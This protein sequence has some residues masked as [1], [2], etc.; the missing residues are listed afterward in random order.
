MGNNILA[1]ETG[2]GVGGG[3]GGCGLA[4]QGCRKRAVQIWVERQISYRTDDIMSKHVI[5]PLPPHPL[6]PQN[7]SSD[8]LGKKKK[9]EE[10]T[11]V[12]QATKI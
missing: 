5:I 2:I 6:S 8:K 9:K 10:N 1:R 3:K 4:G 11:H 7:K 12:A